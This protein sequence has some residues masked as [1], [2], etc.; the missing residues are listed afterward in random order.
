[1]KL[2]KNCGIKTI[3]YNPKC[4]EIDKDLIDFEINDLRQVKNLIKTINNKLCQEKNF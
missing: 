2:G 3:F 1:M 4:L